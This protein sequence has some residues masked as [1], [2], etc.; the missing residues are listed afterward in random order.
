MLLIFAKQS[1]YV[2]YFSVNL[3]RIKMKVG[4]QWTVLNMVT[5]FRSLSLDEAAGLVIIG[6]CSIFIRKY[7]G[8]DV[9]ILLQLTPHFPT[10][11]ILA[12]CSTY[13]LSGRKLHQG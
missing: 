5:I 3:K 2:A 1:S 4:G 6:F 8:L 9:S 7:H 13:N 10:L 11:K 12:Q